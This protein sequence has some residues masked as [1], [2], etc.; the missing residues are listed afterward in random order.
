[1]LQRVSLSVAAHSTDRTAR[2]AELHW[3]LNRAEPLQR[4][5]AGGTARSARTAIEKIA[6]ALR[7]SLRLR[8][9]N[10]GAMDLV[11]SLLRGWEHEP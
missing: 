2:R 5:G 10:G 6:A 1:M 7:Q 8:A 9:A 11:A 4:R 3:T